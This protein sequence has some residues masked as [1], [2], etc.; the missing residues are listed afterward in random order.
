M[1]QA[2]FFLMI[3]PVKIYDKD[4]GLKKVVSSETLCKRSIKE[5]DQIR[6]PT[7]K[8]G[9][10]DQALWRVYRCRNCGVRIKSKTEKAMFCSVYCS[11]YWT[12]IVSTGEG[13]SFVN[14]GLDGYPQ[15]K[16]ELE[17]RIASNKVFN[18]YE[19]KPIKKRDG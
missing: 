19:Y 5:L 4:G 17:A 8:Y 7:L 6:F 10:A 3:Y 13:E 14:G 9:P 15:A 1:G 12:K 16:A 2:P 11:G 18:K